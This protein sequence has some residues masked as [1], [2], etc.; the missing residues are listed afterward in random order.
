[1]AF[2]PSSKLDNSRSIHCVNVHNLLV[3]P[4]CLPLL[5]YTWHISPCIIS[6]CFLGKSFETMSIC[7]NFCLR[8]ININD[9]EY[10]LLDGEVSKLD[11]FIF[12][13]LVRKRNRDQFVKDKNSVI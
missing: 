7:R 6:V 1:M 4:L 11:V 12:L 10:D 5:Y 3:N 2:K 13:Y 8:H 9:K